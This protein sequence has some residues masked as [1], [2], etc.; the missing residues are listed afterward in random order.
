MAKKNEKLDYKALRRSLKEGGPGRLYLLYG[1][2]TYLRDDFLGLL[3]S[4]CVPEGGEDFSCRR[5][6]GPSVDMNELSDAVNALPFMSERSLTELRGFDLNKCKDADFNALEK[7]IADIPDCATLCIVQSAGW[8]PD[9]RLKALKA[10]K[11]R[12]EVI[13]FTAQDQGAL[14]DWIKRR[15]AALG[16]DIDSAVAIRLISASGVYMAGLIPEIEKLAA[17]AA[18]ERISARDVEG[19]AHHLPEAHIFAMTDAMSERNWNAA[20]TILA[21]LMASGEEPVKTLFMIGQQ[22]RNLYVAWLAREEGLGRA[23]ILEVCGLRGREFAADKLVSA[24]RCFSKEQLRRAVELCAE[25]DYAMK[26][27]SVDDGDLLKELFV[28]L[29]EACP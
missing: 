26:S 3:R 11:K 16:K 18:G 13:N 17:S 12:G 1:M 8:E 15:F 25:T 14:V 10:V 28:K 29:A 6:E 22:F 2:E 5:I 24:A 27:S 7:I 21:E 9:M 4:M 23:Y 20:A 19:F